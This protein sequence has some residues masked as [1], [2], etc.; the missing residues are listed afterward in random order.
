MRY[1][2]A[3]IDDA[4]KAVESW[5]FR[6]LLNGVCC[7]SYK[8]GD[9]DLEQEFGAMFFHPTER[10][11]LFEQIQRFKTRCKVLPFIVSDLENGPGDMILGAARFPSMMGISQTGSEKLAYEI[12]CIAAAE[13]GSIGYNWT[14]SPCVDLA[15]EPD[16]PV[17]GLRSAGKD[18]QHVIKM[19]GA[20]M[21]GMQDSGMMATIKHFPGDGYT[22]WDQHLTTPVS[23]LTKDDWWN[24]PGRVYQDLINEGVVAVMPGHIALPAY[25]VADVRGNHPPA[26]VSKRLL[27]DV[28]RAEMGFKGLVVTDAISMG[29]L[30][31]YV[32]YYDACA[33][34]LEGGCDMLLFPRIN[35]RFYEQ[36]EKRLTSGRLTME[37]LRERARRVLALKEQRGLLNDAP[38]MHLPVDQQKQQEVA[39]DMVGR[40]ITVVRDRHGLLPFRIKRGTRILHVV[41]MNNADRYTDLL[42][43]M[44][45]ELAKYSDHVQQ[46][47]DPGPDRLFDAAMDTFDLILCSIGNQANYGLN[48]ARL[49]GEVAR[50]M[51]KGW[52]KLGTPVIFVSHFHPFVHKEYPHSIDTII[53]TY[54]DIECTT[55]QLIK[56][57]TGGQPLQH[58]L[59]AHD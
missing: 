2:I 46:W 4:C 25:D 58:T 17:V 40:S 19:A 35:E 6:R 59:Y 18:P 20:Y 31:G 7:P 29:G 3:D 9:S 57:I 15:V 12:G 37:T 42:L 22:T 50:N 43:R 28:L 51:M 24:G 5:S 38:K 34:A 39:A 47:I 26:T 8:D 49:H 11:K 48:V 1:C 23:N 10:E 55:A 32:N 56:A 54:G 52:S 21:R 45:N 53:N 14:F 36:M 27:Q 41:I 13:A 30:V 16:S 44:K 33:D